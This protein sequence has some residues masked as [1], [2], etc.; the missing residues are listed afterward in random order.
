MI[1]RGCRKDLYFADVFGKVSNRH[2]RTNYVQ[3][4]FILHF[5]NVIVSGG[6]GG[7]GGGSSSSSKLSEKFHTGP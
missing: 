2:F 4:P 5:N 1:L 7:G 3:Y 6:G